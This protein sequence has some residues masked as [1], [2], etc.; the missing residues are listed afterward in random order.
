MGLHPRA[1]ALARQSDL[2]GRQSGRTSRVVRPAGGIPT[3]HS[4]IPTGHA[5]LSQRGWPVPRAFPVTCSLS[6]SPR[7]LTANSATRASGKVCRADRRNTLR[8][9]AGAESSPV[10]ASRD[11]DRTVLPLEVQRKLAKPAMLFGWTSTGGLRRERFWILTSTYLI[12]TFRGS[13]GGM[14]IWSVRQLFR[15]HHPGIPAI[16]R[17]P[18]CR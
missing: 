15:S 14:I 5:S 6:I 10:N 2:A 16:V 4:L 1:R 8:C 17:S 18:L 13:W 3:P 7:M 11:Q 9:R 12:F